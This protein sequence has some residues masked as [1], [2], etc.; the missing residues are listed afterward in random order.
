MRP[1]GEAAM[2]EAAAR[3]GLGFCL[4]TF[5]SMPHERVFDSPE[6]PAL[7][8]QQIYMLRQREITEAVIERARAAGARA[9]VL[10]VDLPEVG[11]R[12]R[13]AEGDFTSFRLSAPWLVSD[14]DIRKRIIEV[15]GVP[16]DTPTTTSWT[17]ASPHRRPPS[18]TSPS[19]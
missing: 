8:L 13:D 14:P 11:H 12:E 16:S 19:S 7:K 10:T 6:S 15:A 3:T 18:T 4:S 2:A 5:A 1:Q 17:T 9:L